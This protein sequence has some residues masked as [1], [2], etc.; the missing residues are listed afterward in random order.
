MYW[1]LADSVAA[2]GS[3]LDHVSSPVARRLLEHITRHTPA[4]TNPR[5]EDTY[6]AVEYRQQH[7]YSRRIRK[8]LYGSGLAQQLAAGDGFLPD[9][10]E[11]MARPWA[12]IWRLTKPRTLS[13][14]VSLLINFLDW[15][16][17]PETPLPL[18]RQIP[19]LLASPWTLATVLGLYTWMVKTTGIIIEPTTM[20]VALV[21]F[22]MTF[23]VLAYHQYARNRIHATELY[24]YL[25]RALADVPE[26]EEYANG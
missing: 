7:K 24:H 25:C 23:V 12:G 2:G 10:Y 17:E 11:S 22:V 15:Y 6:V 14:Q 8:L 26:D 21:T 13:Q 1:T 19:S 3:L 4:C 5:S 9:I 20:L 18:D 16:L